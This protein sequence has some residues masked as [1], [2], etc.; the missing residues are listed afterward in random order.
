MKGGV[1]QKMAEESKE[2]VKIQNNW[3]EILELEYYPV[4]EENEKRIEARIEEKSGIGWQKRAILLM[5]KNIKNIII[6]QKVELYG[7]KC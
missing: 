2:S 4:P 6:W 7:K 5:G 1:S 3:Y